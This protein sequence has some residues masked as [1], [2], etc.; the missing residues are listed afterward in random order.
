MQIQLK[1]REY[2]ELKKQI[3]HHFKVFDG[4]LYHV[5]ELGPNQ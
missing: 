3:I 1:G 5:L 4:R 2:R